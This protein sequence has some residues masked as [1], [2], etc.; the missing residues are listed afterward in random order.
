VSKQIELGESLLETLYPSIS[1]DT[2]NVCPKCT[3][4][5]KEDDICAG[6]IPCASSE[7][8]TRCS[9]CSHRF[10]AKFT[11]TCSSP[12]F[13]GSQG[14]GTPLY[15]DHLSPWVLLREMRS[16]INATGGIDSILDEKFR[17]GPEVSATL[18]WNTILVFKRYKLPFIFLLQGSF[19]NNLILPSPSLNESMTD[20]SH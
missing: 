1:I 7:Y 2:E 18:W 6:W 8:E 17:C 16:V 13:E 3:A 12:T 10:V 20:M 19:H 11:V 14:K 4:V 15:C 5:L 9:S